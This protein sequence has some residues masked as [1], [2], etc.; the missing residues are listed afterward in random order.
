[1]TRRVQST[2]GFIELGSAPI[3]I[4]SRGSL[5]PEASAADSNPETPLAGAE[6]DRLLAVGRDITFAKRRYQ[7]AAF[8]GSGGTGEAYRVESEGEQFVL[9]LY[10]PSYDLFRPL[11]RTTGDAAWEGLSALVKLARA[12][13]DALAGIRHPHIVHVYANDQITLHV[14]E[15]TR[16]RKAVPQAIKQI[17]GIITEYI[18]GLPL[19]AAIVDYALTGDDVARV[20]SETAQALDY[21]HSRRQRMHCDVRPSNI[22]VRADSRTAVLVDFALTKNFNDDEVA[23]SEKTLMVVDPTRVPPDSELARAIARGAREGLTRQEVLELAFP[24]LD[25]YQ[26]GLTMRDVKV[27]TADLF[28]S[29][30]AGYYDEICAELTNW[31]LARS[32]SA[33]ALEPRLRRLGP[34]HFY[35][36]GVVELAQVSSE[37]RTIP[38]P[39]GDEIPLVGNTAAI[40]AN[41]SFRRLATINQLS[42]VGFIYPAA[43]YKRIVHVYYAYDLARRLIRHLLGTPIFRSVFDPKAVQQLLA[44]V[45]LHDINHFPFLH[46]VQEASF[47]TNRAAVDFFC[48]G[49]ATGEKAANEPGIFDL[50]EGIGLDRERFIRVTYGKGQDQRSEVDQIIH[51]IINSGCD[52]DKMSYL[53]LDSLFTGVRY[54]QGLDLNTL[55]QAATVARTKDGLLHLAYDARAI[56]AVE[57][58]FMTRYW[59]FRTIYWHHTNRALMAMVLQVLRSLYESPGDMTEYLAATKYLG[60]LGTLGWLNQQHQARFG[61]PSILENLVE[62]RKGIYRRLYTVQPASTSSEDIDSLLF[63]RVSKLAGVNAPPASALALRQ[64]VADY[65]SARCHVH[66]DVREVLIDVPGRDLNTPGQ[67]YIVSDAAETIAVQELSPPIR[68]LSTNYDQLAKRIRFFISPRAAALVG[69]TRGPAERKELRL[70]LKT[71]VGGLSRP[72]SGATGVS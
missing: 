59:H 33:E 65:L 10:V 5:L 56:Q 21:I 23:S 69:D 19:D 45:L 44:V 9:K 24:T 60:D 7:V 31:D 66:I 67:A 28:D 3:S 39:A 57:N 40:V 50:L 18:D 38:M 15:F 62:D 8:I 70:A 27:H 34:R 17:P 35:P 53:T 1:V 22:L 6:N 13:Y 58:V 32:R 47:P 41:R 49:A 42:L 4:N 63:E 37:D 52:V 14:N 26:F 54:G 51:S 64:A 68:W 20:L 36:F 12:E 43:D 55:L 16:L 61:E 71:L 46:I 30:E 11:L 48:S 25:L 2:R 72:G 29:R